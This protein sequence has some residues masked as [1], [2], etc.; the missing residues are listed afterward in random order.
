METRF[1]PAPVQPGI[2][3]SYRPTARQYNVRLID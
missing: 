2:S 1:E 3:K